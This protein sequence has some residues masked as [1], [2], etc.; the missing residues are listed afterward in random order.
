MQTAS[1]VGFFR[2]ILIIILIYYVFKFLARLFMPILLR[3]MVQKAEQS[4][5]Q[6]TNQQQQEP[7]STSTSKFENPKTKKE[8]GEYIDYE[9][10]D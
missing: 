4:F 6:Q 2:T 7:A 5:K 10:V 1:F 3:K 9:E 8:V